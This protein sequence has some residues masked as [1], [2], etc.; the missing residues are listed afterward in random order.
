MWIVPDDEIR[1]KAR[2][3]KIL[4]IK[5]SKDKSYLAQ[6]MRMINFHD[7]KN[8]AVKKDNVSIRNIP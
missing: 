4:K 6:K 1:R 8:I 3:R 2:P 7:R 5:Y